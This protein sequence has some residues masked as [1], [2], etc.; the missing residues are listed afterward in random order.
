MSS[1]LSFSLCNYLDC[2]LPFMPAPQFKYFML[3]IPKDKWVPILPEGIAY[4]K[5]QEESGDSGYLHWQIMVISKKKCTVTRLK[6]FFC[7]EAHVEPSRSQAA[8]EYVWKEESRVPG[9]QFELGE[10]PMNRNSKEDWALIKQQAKEGRLDDI[11]ADIYIRHYSALR[12]ISVEYQKPIIRGPQEVLVIYGPTGVGK[13]RMA[14]A[15]AGDNFYIKSPLTKWFDG[16]HGQEVIIIDEF[17]GIVDISHVLK[18]LDRYP[19]SVEVKGSQV[20]LNTKKWI[21]TSNLSPDQWY[22]L[23]DQET[24][25]ALR[26]RFSR[27]IHKLNGL[28]SIMNQ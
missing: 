11:P 10:K 26:R 16:Y 19:C 7:P 3:T 4:I 2:F 22:P 25:F 17:R 28:E 1:L 13:S 24:K 18:W 15:E 6:G 20:F 27:V 8:E 5:G 23:L 9:S 12:K 14:F 21:I